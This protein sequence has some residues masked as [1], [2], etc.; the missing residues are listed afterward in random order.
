M[1]EGLVKKI[2]SAANKE[3]DREPG[4]I[5]KAVNWSWRMLMLVL[6]VI[7]LAGAWTG[8]ITRASFDK[9]TAIYSYSSAD[10]LRNALKERLT[11]CEASEEEKACYRNTVQATI[12]Y[13]DKT[14][15]AQNKARLPN[16]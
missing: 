4:V 8:Y 10:G 5:R 2:A 15:G 1:N 9:T 3:S 6:A 11:E 13:L 7:F 12:K 14:Y 16:P